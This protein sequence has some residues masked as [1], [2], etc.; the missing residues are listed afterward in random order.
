MFAHG[1]IWAYPTDTSFGL[2]VRID[3]QEGLSALAQL[4]SRPSTKPFSLMVRDFAMLQHYAVVP[5]TLT[6]VD[7]FRKPLTCIFQR[8]RSPP[9][10]R[11]GS[12]VG[13]RTY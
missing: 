2:G 3:D 7:F 8:A 10:A 6:E 5:R 11:A 1:E 12:A 9:R 13:S 4:K